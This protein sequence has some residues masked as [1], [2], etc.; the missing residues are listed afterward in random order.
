MVHFDDK[1]PRR[2]ARKL[3]KLDQLFGPYASEF[4]PG[5]GLDPGPLSL[6]YSTQPVITLVEDIDPEMTDL[7]AGET[8]D[9]RIEARQRLPERRPRPERRGRRVRDDGGDV[10]PLP[11][12]RPRRGIK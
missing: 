9:G 1:L 6:A 2:P 3:K 5:E 12:D 7:E 11:A 4:L 8:A 10:R